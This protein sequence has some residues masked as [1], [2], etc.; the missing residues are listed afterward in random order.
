VFLATDWLKRDIEPIAVSYAAQCLVP[1]HYEEIRKRREEQV[2]KTMA[3]VKER[4]TVEINHWDRTLEKLRQE[5][6]A[7]KHQKLNSDRARLRRDDLRLRLEKRLDELK[8]ERQLSRGVPNVVGGALIV[9]ASMLHGG[10]GA[11]GHPPMHAKQTREVELLAMEAVMVLERGLGFEP[12]DVS[13]DRRGYDVESKRP[14]GSLRFIEVK[15]RVVGADTVTVTKN[16][17]LVAL[18][19]PDD[20]ILAIVEVDGVAGKPVYIQNPFG[21]EPDFGV[22]AV[23]Y[24]VAEL[25]TKVEV[26]A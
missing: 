22:T 2:D 6:E 5:E 4:L 1:E 24:K 18:N 14:D 12:V 19:K 15:G 11:G 7:G 20:Y 17:V 16:E 26:L 21:R 8:Q 3:A 9:P 25:K 10:S 13:A 23:T